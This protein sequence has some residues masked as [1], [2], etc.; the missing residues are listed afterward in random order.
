MAEY[1]VP[2]LNVQNG[3]LKSISFLFEYIGE[4][5]IDYLYAVTPLLVDALMDRDHVHR[6]IAAAA[7]RHMALGSFGLGCEDALLHLLNNVWPNIFEQSP[8]VIIA[9]MDALEGLSLALGP[10]IL[11]LYLAQGLFHPARRVRQAAWRVYNM[12][13]VQGQETLVPLFPSH[14][15]VLDAQ[16]YSRN[17]LYLVL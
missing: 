3:V 1:R 11:F 7:V 8:H 9:V 13:Y 2:E 16:R 5:G 14:G 10:A 4:V 12:L 15:E 6:Q 17:H